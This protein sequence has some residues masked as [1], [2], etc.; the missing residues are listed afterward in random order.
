MCNLQRLRTP[1]G[2]LAFDGEFVLPMTRRK[3]LENAGVQYRVFAVSIGRYVDGLRTGAVPQPDEAPE[4]MTLSGALAILHRVGPNGLVK[5]A[6]E[7]AR[8][9]DTNDLYLRTNGLF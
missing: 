4:G 1:I 5:W 3:F 8:F 7:S 2:R 9:S 6:D